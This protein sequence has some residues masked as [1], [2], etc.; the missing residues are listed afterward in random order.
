MNTFKRGTFFTLGTIFI[1]AL[2]MAMSVILIPLIADSLNFS[3]TVFGMLIAIPGA[4][5]L[6]FEIPLAAWSDRIGRKP[7][8]MGGIFSGVVGAVLLAW[9][10]DAIPLI[11]FAFANSFASV[12]FFPS[13]LAYLS[14]VSRDGRLAQVQGW[15]GFIQGLAF[16][17]GAWMAGLLVSRFSFQ[18]ALLTA[19]LGFSLSL[20]LSLFITETSNPLDVK[21][22]ELDE[23][24]R[25]YQAVVDLVKQRKPIQ[26]AVKVEVLYSIL[27]VVLG[28]AFFPLYITTTD[29]GSAAFAGNLVS[30][31]NLSSTF[32]SLLYGR[33]VRTFGTIKPLFPMLFLTA[34]TFLFLPSSDGKVLWY[35]LILLQGMGVGFI[36]AAPNVLIADGTGK[37]E[38]ALGYASVTVISRFMQI[39]FPP[40]FGALADWAGLRTVF[41]AGGALVL[42]VIL[43]ASRNVKLTG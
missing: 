36:P 31:R 43:W 33:A 29:L 1:F 38:R 19:A 3:A 27:I 14:E 8:L 42:A 21:G 10:I 22:F 15:N 7:I 37:E 30:V 40:L 28:N 12:L 17:V 4:I 25:T 41:W 5:T 13:I 6:I 20:L 24:K 39:V 16:S 18:T 26:L 23:L 9:R 32:V 34:L 11:L 35:A 2:S